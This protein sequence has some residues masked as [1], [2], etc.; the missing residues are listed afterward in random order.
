MI[1]E[2]ISP[3]SKSVRSAGDNNAIQSATSYRSP[4]FSIQKTVLRAQHIFS[5]PLH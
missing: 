1:A 5:T 2:V 3:L 4:N